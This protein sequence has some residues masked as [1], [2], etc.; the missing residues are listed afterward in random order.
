MELCW[1]HKWQQQHQQQP[2]KILINSMNSNGTEMNIE[3]HY[4]A[5]ENIKYI[6]LSQNECGPNIF[7]WME[8]EITM[9]LHYTSQERKISVKRSTF[10]RK[11]N[12]CECCFEFLVGLLYTFFVLSLKLCYCH[13]PLPIQLS[14]KKNPKNSENGKKMEGTKVNT[15]KIEWNEGKIMW[16]MNVSKWAQSTYAKMC[17][18]HMCAHIHLTQWHHRL[19]LLKGVRQRE[20][21]SIFCDSS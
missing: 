8:N 5:F 9:I 3:K 12:V 2:S 15:I 11:R 1:F 16:K 18:H 4:S 20:R 7:R 10:V 21:E 13:C 19:I 6:Y 17:V 14:K